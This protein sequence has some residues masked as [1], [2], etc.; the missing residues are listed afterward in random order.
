MYE[1]VEEA[2]LCVKIKDALGKYETGR[3]RRQEIIDALD[4]R[5]KEVEQRMEDKE[6]RE[7]RQK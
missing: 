1:K 4:Q 2:N 3:K 5:E 6:W 7:S